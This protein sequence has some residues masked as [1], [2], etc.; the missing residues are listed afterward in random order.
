MFL[1]RF[2]LCIEKAGQK[3]FH[4]IFLADS[5]ERFSCLGAIYAL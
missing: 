4:A 5:P 3:E 1:I 2:L